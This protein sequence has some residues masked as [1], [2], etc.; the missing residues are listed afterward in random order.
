MKAESA[1]AREASWSVWRQDDSGNR[2]E[3]A[4]G[5][6]RK[7]AEASV[8]VLRQEAT[9]RHTGLNQHGGNNSRRT[10][11]WAPLF[12]HVGKPACE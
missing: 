7:A 8:K 11:T 2:F 10:F 9:S 4:R 1:S 12:Q 6:S 3:I 5:L